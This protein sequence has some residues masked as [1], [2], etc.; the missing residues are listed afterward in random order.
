MID[1]NDRDSA[2]DLRAFAQDAGIP[3]NVPVV[4]GM[5]SDGRIATGYSVQAL[6]T[7]V[8]IDAQGRLAY[9]SDGPV[10]TA[11][12]AQTLKGLP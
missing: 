6:E 12:L 9:R 8:V 1:L 4:W 2:A 3:A 11:Q 10:P 5:D 7:T